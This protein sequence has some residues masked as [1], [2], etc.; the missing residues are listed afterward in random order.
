MSIRHI[1]K[2]YMR[3]IEHT[4]AGSTINETVRS[5][6]FHYIMNDIE[7]IQKK[8]RRSRP[9]TREYQNLN[10]ELRQLMLKEIQV[11]IDDYVIARQNGTLER[12]ERM[13]GD[14]AW[15]VRH[16]Y[17]YR[18]V[19]TAREGHHIVDAYGFYDQDELQCHS[20]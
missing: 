20:Q 14:I 2:L 18:N 8:M 12:W 9:G 19:R 4:P 13:Y 1:E 7:R 17:Q 3:M 5:R 11:I 15:Y 6:I 10:T 16:Y